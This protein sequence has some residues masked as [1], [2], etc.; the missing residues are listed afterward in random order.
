MKCQKCSRTATEHITEIHQGAAHAELHFCDK[1]AR[2]YLAQADL[3]PQ[4][5]ANSLMQFLAQTLG[6]AGPAPSR[7]E[8]ECPMCGWSLEE[9][10]ASGRLGC[11]HDW[12]EFCDEL[13]DVL[14]TLHGAN[15][16]VG[17]HPKSNQ[18][19]DLRTELIRLRRDMQ[20]AV[21][22]EDYERASEIRDR[23][24]DIEF[25]DESSE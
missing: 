4:A 21:E 24:R 19:T 10:Q 22:L 18:D 2:E 14:I 1:H 8:K 13:E 11:P 16:H 23:I 15:Q 20:Q 5:S 12:V 25:S 17:K 3:E 6:D 9:L 7:A